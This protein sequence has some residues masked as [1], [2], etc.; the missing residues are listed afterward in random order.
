[1]HKLCAVVLGQVQVSQLSRQQAGEVQPGGPAHGHAPWSM[2]SQGGIM[3]S[4]CMS[5]LCT[6]PGTQVL[7]GWSNTHKK[8]FHSATPLHTICTHITYQQHI[9]SHTMQFTL[10]TAKPACVAHKVSAVRVT[11]T[12]AVSPVA[13]AVAAEKVQAYTTHNRGLYE[14]CSTCI[15]VLPAAVLGVHCTHL[16]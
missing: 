2:V 12:A 6:P 13:S 16:C 14:G 10:Q 11:R 3:S 15:H 7:Q 9:P 4:L 1:M 8:H 5:S